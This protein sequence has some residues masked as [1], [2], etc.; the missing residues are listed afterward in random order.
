VALLPVDRYEDWAVYLS[1]NKYALQQ[2][3][4]AK[5]AVPLPEI[6]KLYAN[7]NAPGDHSDSKGQLWMAYPRPINREFNLGSYLD[8][9]LPI[10]ISGVENGFRYNADSYPITGTEEPWL[11]TSGVEG[12]LNI[13]IQLSATAKRNYRVELLFVETETD[14]V[15]QRVFDVKIQGRIVLPQLDIAARA[16][17]ANHA[18]RQTF[19]GIAAQEAMTIELVPVQG[20]APRICSL[21]IQQEGQDG[22]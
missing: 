22:Q 18:L 16:G 10:D 13:T 21:S 6:E 5:K 8:T 4:Q 9:S 1:G 14:E 15:G 17:Q 3:K 11:F 7:L 19:E 20:K 2:R 12:P